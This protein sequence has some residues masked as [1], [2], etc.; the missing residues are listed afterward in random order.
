[1]QLRN[2]KCFQPHF[3]K[4]SCLYVA[5]ENK[6]HFHLNVMSDPFRVEY[7]FVIISVPS[8]DFSHLHFEVLNYF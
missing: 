6:L 5:A 1:M 2:Q 8:S 3:M 4:L 7:L